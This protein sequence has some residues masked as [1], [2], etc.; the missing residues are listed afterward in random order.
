MTIHDLAALVSGGLTLILLATTASVAMAA[1]APRS[2]DDPPLRVGFCT[3]DLAPAKAAGFDYAEIGIR[4]FTAL[5]DA[6]LEALVRAHRSAGLPTEAGYVFLPADLKIVGPNVDDEK[7]LAYVTK[8]LARCERLGVRLIVFGSPAARRA[9]EGFSKAEAFAQLVALGKRIAPLAQ[10]HGV[11]LAAE[12]IRRSETNMINTVAEG[13]AWVDAVGHPSFRFMVDLFHLVEEGEDPSVLRAAGA[14]LV[15]AKLANPK[16]RVFPLPGDGY[17]Y[18]PFLRALRATGYRGPIG[19]ETPRDRLEA[20]GSRS[21][22]FVKAAWA[23]A[24]E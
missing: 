2:A 13:L 22:A 3:N 24:K 16:G 11:V 17:D 20:D 15:Y 7:V 19:M 10:T 9:P 14:R 8:A 18:G 12:P 1:G 23:A 4:D 6:D 21:I 5:P